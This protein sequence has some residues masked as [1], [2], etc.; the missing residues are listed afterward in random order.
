MPGHLRPW[1][2]GGT[3]VGIG[4]DDEPLDVDA[5]PIVVGEA[6][7]RRAGKV[8]IIFDKHVLAGWLKPNQVAVGAK[9]GR[10]L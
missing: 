7:R 4:K 1:F 9:L 10:R 5:R 3:L 6:W 8:S 2:A